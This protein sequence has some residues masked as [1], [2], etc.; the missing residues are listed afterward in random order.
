MKGHLCVFSAELSW[1]ARFEKEGRM[2][3]ERQMEDSSQDDM[4]LSA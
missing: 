4:C 3:L 1:M 2:D